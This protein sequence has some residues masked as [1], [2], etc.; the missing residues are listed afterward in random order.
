MQAKGH[1]SQKSRIDP[2]RYVLDILDHRYRSVGVRGQ[3]SASSSNSRTN[4]YISA[5]WF[6]RNSFEV[7]KHILKLRAW[8]T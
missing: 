3:R 5:G 8:K 4:R 7:N 6:M 2:V 1:Q